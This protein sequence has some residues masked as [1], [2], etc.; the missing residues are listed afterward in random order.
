MTAATV[1]TKTHL[2]PPAARPSARSSRSAST[3]RRCTRSSSRT[4]RARSCSA[5][6]STTARA[7]PIPDARDRD[8]GRRRGRRRS[9]ARA[10]PSAA[11]TTPSPAS[12]ARRPPTTGHYEFWTRNPGAGRRQGAVLRGDRVRARPARQAAHPH[13]PSRA[14]KTLLA[15]DA[16]LSSLDA[17]RARYAHRDAHARRRTCTTTSGCRARRRPCSLP[18][19]D[20]PDEPSA[21]LDVGLLSP[22]TVGLR[23]RGDGCRVPRRARHRRGRARPAR[24]AGVGRRRRASRDE[25][26]RPL[27]LDGA[28]EPCAAPRIDVARARGGIRRRRQSG[29]PAHRRACK[30]RVAGDPDA[31]R[32]G[33]PRRDESGHPRLGAD[34]RSAAA[35][36]RDGGR[37]P[38]TQPTPRSRALAQAHRDD[39]ARR[40][41]RSPSTRVPTTVGLRAANWLRGD[42]ARASRG[43]RGALRALPAQ[44]GGAG[45]TLASFVELVRR[46]G[47]AAASCPRAFAAR[48]GARGARRAVAHRPLAGHRARRCA[49]RRRSTRVGVFGAGRRDARPHRDRRARRRRGRRIRRRCRRSRTR[50][51]PSSSAPPRCARRS[52]ARPL[53]LAAGLAVD[54]RP[55]GAWHAEWPTLR[56]C[57]ASRSARRRAPRASPAGLARRRRP[58]VARNLAL[59]GG[60]IVTRAARHR[61]GA[62][63]S[64]ESRFDALDR[65]GRGAAATSRALRRERCPRRRDLDVDA[66]LDPAQY[67]GLAVA[68]VDEALREAAQDGSAMTVPAIALTAPRRPGRRAARRARPVAR[69]LDDPVGGRRPGCSPSDY[70]VVA[71]DLPGHG[72]SRA[73][74]RAVH[75]RRPR[76][77]GRRRGR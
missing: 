67:I 57:C 60:L 65:G 29:D 24:W 70:R 52:S 64:A 43:C 23:R 31:A 46:A 21:A 6:P 76:R 9:R 35:R 36:P 77:R 4:A 32:L 48:A 47:A 28:G 58:A 2:R 7:Q 17:G 55:D 61:A 10:A 45:G 42:P 53:H 37:Q 8:L 11:T 68:L 72:A 50:R 73:G 63:A 39:V 5:A 12:A 71:W 66:L 1:P 62:A 41:A 40:R 30:A 25:I 51:H 59:T 22:V 74:T 16:L 38:R 13:L 15:A 75:G 19:D 18:S 33:A 3:T 14:T 44:L 27:R 69:H 20:R 56:S 34:A 49:R 54:E 26:S